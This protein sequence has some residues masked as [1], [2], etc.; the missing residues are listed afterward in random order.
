[1]TELVICRGLPACGKTTRAKAWVAEDP[2]SRARVNRDELRGMC[3]DGVWLGHDTER[4]IQSV[5]DAAIAALL[6]RGVS[7]VCDDTNLPQRVARDIARIG[8]LA[9]ADVTVC[10]T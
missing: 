3:H 8:R 6:K 10:G 1:V 5:R 7:V 9:G 2:V 4:Q